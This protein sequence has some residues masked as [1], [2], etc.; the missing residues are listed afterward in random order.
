MST[1]A[2]WAIRVFWKLPH[3]ARFEAHLTDCAGIAVSY[4]PF[5]APE[6]RLAHVLRIS[7]L[8]DFIPRF[9]D[10]GNEGVDAV[11]SLHNGKGRRI[12]SIIGGHFVQRFP[13]TLH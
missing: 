3:T 10:A 5:G 4:A 12:R 8:P 7:P 11:A 13:R 2:L 9:D 1:L 6:L